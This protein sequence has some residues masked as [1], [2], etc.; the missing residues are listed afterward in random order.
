MTDSPRRRKFLL[1]KSSSEGKTKTPSKESPLLPVSLTPQP[2]RTPFAERLS[3]E[4]PNTPP[5]IENNFDGLFSS[6]RRQRRA[7]IP[8]QTTK[9][10]SVSMNFRNV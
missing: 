1:L 3:K 8:R 9:S 7:L 6:P 2:S 10:E 4:K 5:V